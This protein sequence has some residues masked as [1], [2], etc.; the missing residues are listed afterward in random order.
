[1][2]NDLP[3]KMRK[4]TSKSDPARNEVV[5]AAND[6]VLTGYLREIAAFES[7]SAEEEK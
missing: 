6:S 7:L 4:T 1:M 5:E 2:S 3:V